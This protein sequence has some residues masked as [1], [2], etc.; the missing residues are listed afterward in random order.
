[1]EE[2]VDSELVQA[3]NPYITNEDQPRR[4][5]WKMPLIIA[6]VI[7]FVVVAV[8]V[9]RNGTQEDANRAADLVRQHPIVIE[10]L[11][12]IDQ[13]SHNFF[14]SLNEGG[15]RTDVLDVKGPKG[16]GRLITFELFFKYRSIV[17]QTDE[18]EWELIEG[19]TDP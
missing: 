11:G 12:G 15:K 17:L 14:A 3:E 16:S 13:C 6:G 18:G 10:Q 1:M 9:I 5:P 8:I 4:S 7:A 19:D 2:L